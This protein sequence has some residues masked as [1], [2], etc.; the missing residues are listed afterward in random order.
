M[1]I[2]FL[3]PTAGLG[4][5][6]SIRGIPPVTFSSTVHPTAWQRASNHQ[7]ILQDGQRGEG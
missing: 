3:I 7:E 6:D 1:L 4:A 2:H 5:R